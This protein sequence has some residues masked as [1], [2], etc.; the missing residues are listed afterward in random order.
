V[1]HVDSLLADLD[2]IGLAAWHA[3]ISQLLAERL[4]PGAHG[5]LAE[6]QDIL[7][8]LPTA[9]DPAAGADST[10][11][12]LKQL[13]PWRKGPFDIGNI[14][15]DAEWRSDMKW[16][17][18]AGEIGPLDGRSI[19]DV[20]CGNGYYAMRMV[21]AGAGLVIGIDPTLLFVAQ[22]AAIRKLKGTT[23]VHVLPLRM[24][25][26]PPNARTFDTTFSMGVLYHRR[27]PLSHLQQLR[28]SLSPGGELVLETLVYPGEHRDII[29]PEGRYARMRNVWHLPTVPALIEW[30]ESAGFLDVRV[31]DVTRTTTAEQRATDWMRFESLREALD[32]ADSS[33]TIEG[34]PAPTRAVLIASAP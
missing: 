10:A 1:V 9:G 32:P 22:F 19:L 4:A 31:I 5:H 6:W 12:R 3:P 11:K 17:R 24:E 28:D 8:A 23:R 33:R 7:D 20:G 25:E 26:L 15:I 16:A 14:H 21:E 18:L 29:E 13:S 2:R 27:E 34:L 30:V